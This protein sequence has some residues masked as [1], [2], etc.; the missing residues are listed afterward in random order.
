G[1]FDGNHAAGEQGLGGVDEEFTTGS[2]HD[3]DD[4]GL[5][6]TIERIAGGHASPFLSE[7]LNSAAQRCVCSGAAEETHSVARR[8]RNAS[9][10]DGE[11]PR[12]EGRWR[13]CQAGHP[14]RDVHKMEESLMGRLSPPCARVADAGVV[15]SICCSRQ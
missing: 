3:G 9:L 1:D 15:C 6:D 11:P 2:P 7:S 12:K 10:R 4:A 8:T 13:E 5:K 14:S